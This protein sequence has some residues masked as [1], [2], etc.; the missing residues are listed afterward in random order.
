MP[1]WSRL[2]KV[3]ARRC[4]LSA[5]SSTDNFISFATFADSSGHFS[6]GPRHDHRHHHRLHGARVSHAEIITKSN[7]T[8]VLTRRTTNSAGVFT[9]SSLQTDTYAI[10]IRSAGFAPIKIENVTLD[11]GLREL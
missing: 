7:S 9:V 10:T 3:S 11:A 5:L 2:R 8:G 4:A 6:D 1:P